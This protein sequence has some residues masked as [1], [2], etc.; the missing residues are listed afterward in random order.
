VVSVLLVGQGGAG[1]VGR[2]RR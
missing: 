1:R 2:T